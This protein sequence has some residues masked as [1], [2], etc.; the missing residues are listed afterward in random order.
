MGNS[1]EPGRSTLFLLVESWTEDMVI[2]GI[3][4][5]D[6]KVLQTSPSGVDE[7][8]LKTAF[9][10]RE[11]AEGIMRGITAQARADRSEELAGACAGLAARGVAAGAVAGVTTGV[12]HGL[13]AEG[14][15]QVVDG[16]TEAGA[17]VTMER[18]AEALIEED[19]AGGGPFCLDWEIEPCKNHRME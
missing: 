9:D 18:A 1:I 16:A 6:A 2:N 13:A 19:K 11:V 15:G 4:G 3:T 7:V 8:K 12:V 14:A 5:F 10:D 17:A